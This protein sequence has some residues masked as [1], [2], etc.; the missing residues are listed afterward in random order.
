MTSTWEPKCA[1]DESTIV[2]VVTFTV[3]QVVI[4]EKQTWRWFFLKL[5]KWKALL[6]LLLVTTAHAFPWVC[7]CVRTYVCVWERK[8]INLSAAC[9]RQNSAVLRP[10]QI[11][12]QVELRVLYFNTNV[13]S[14]NIGL[15]RCDCIFMVWPCLPRISSSLVVLVSRDSTRIPVFSAA[16]GHPQI[17]GW[18][19]FIIGLASKQRD[20]AAKTKRWCS[21]DLRQEIQENENTVMRILVRNSQDLYFQ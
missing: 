2:C 10:M 6:F 21:F 15:A 3:A 8:C 12:Q 17:A 14:E 20:K 4:L 7:V 9:N 18:Q 19:G 1:S 11:W 5:L 16:Q 13:W